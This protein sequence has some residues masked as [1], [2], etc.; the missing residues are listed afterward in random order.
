MIER[1]VVQSRVKTVPSLV[2]V[3]LAWIKQALTWSKHRAVTI[4]VWERSSAIGSVHA[5]LVSSVKTLLV[6][7]RNEVSVATVLLAAVLAPAVTWWVAT[8]SGYPP[9]EQWLVGTW[10]GTDP[11]WIVFAGTAVLVG[12]GTI[13]AAVNSGVIPTSLL[14]MAPLFGLAVTRYGTRYTEPVFGPQV[15]S[16]PEAVEF[17]TAVAALGGLPLALAGFVLGELLRRGFR[18]LEIRALLAP[19]R[20][21]S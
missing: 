17:A 12:I 7:R 4:M 20:S 10:T 14:V 21:D 2:V 9:L 18:R 3:V 13:S 1:E 15:V 16:L 6:G 8:T 5:T 11:Y 19:V